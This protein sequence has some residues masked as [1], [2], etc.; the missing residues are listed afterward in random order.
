MVAF[1]CKHKDQTDD[2]QNRDYNCKHQPEFFEF[3]VHKV[4][5]DIERFS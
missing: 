3:K 2:K 4:A 5:N 1:I